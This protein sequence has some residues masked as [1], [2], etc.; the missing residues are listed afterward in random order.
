MTRLV[1][2][3]LAVMV[4]CSPVGGKRYDRKQAQKSLKKLEAT[5]LVLGEFKLTKVVDGDTI[6]VDGLDSSLRLLGMDAEETF[7]NEADRRAVEADWTRYLK[8]KKGDSRSPVKAAT[9]MGEVAKDFAKKWFDGVRTVRIE[10][11]HPAEIRD[12]FDRYLA[13][14]FA[15]KHGVWL[16]YNVEGVRAG[17]TP[18]FPKYGNSRRFHQ[19]FVAAAAEA[20]AAQRGIWQPG[21]MA[22]PDYP[23]REAWWSARGNFVEAFRKEGEGKPSYIDITHWDALQ[24][25]EAHVGKEVRLLGTIDDI[26]IGQHGPSRVTMSRFPLIFFDND[27]LGTSGL[28]TWRG[29][30]VVVT[31]VPTFYEN[32]KTKQ[33]Q[34]QIVVDRA[35]Q[36]QLCP[37]PGLHAP[38]A[39]TTARAPGP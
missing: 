34:L 9:P 1:V 15:E 22:Y 29:E 2:F 30:F 14:V 20:K 8:T 28:S 35:S 31:G 17:I 6:R 4:A 16:N 21:A 33:K 18:Y 23:E 39:D 27:V 19:E 32:K 5:G 25:L 13:Y 26:R 38:T 11:D 24:Q 36:I 3:L 10:R 7:K 37:V 12:R